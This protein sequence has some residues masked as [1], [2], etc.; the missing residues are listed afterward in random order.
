VKEK[1]NDIVFN[2]V[3]QDQREKQKRESSTHEE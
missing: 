2:C 3:P 1:E